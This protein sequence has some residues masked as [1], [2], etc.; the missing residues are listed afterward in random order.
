MLLP[1]ALI[2]YFCLLSGVSRRHPTILAS[3]GGHF[4]TTVSVI[5]SIA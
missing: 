3:E 4:I 2:G 1:I 5:L